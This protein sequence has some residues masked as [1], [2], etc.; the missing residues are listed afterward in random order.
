MRE[1]RLS[2]VP[3]TT[4]NLTGK[5]PRS[6]ECLEMV[7]NIVR[8]M[9]QLFDRRRPNPLAIGLNTLIEQAI[10]LQ[11]PDVR[12]KGVA[13]D[14]APLG[15]MKD[16]VAIVI[17]SKDRLSRDTTATADP[18]SFGVMDDRSVG[19]V[20]HRRLCGPT[21]WAYPV[22]VSLLDP[23]SDAECVYTDA[24]QVCGN[25][26]KLRRAKANYANDHAVDN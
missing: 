19:S 12:D 10:S 26:A 14:C 3:L 22:R 1:Q 23:R 25:K 11:A 5:M 21:R 4:S 13:I 16:R 24:N 8:E 17:T 7:G 18:R 6:R 15:S 9:R 20:D 2:G